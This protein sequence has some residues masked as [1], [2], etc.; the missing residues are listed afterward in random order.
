[1]LLYLLVVGVGVDVALLSTSL[2]LSTVAIASVKS[3]TQSLTHSLTNSLAQ[4]HTQ[5]L[6]F[7][8]THTLSL[9][10]ADGGLAWHRAVH[11]EAAPQRL[12]AGLLLR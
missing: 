3:H 10:S 5:S 11:S 7:S 6:S 2:L 4:S 8:H 9:R 12:L 1:M